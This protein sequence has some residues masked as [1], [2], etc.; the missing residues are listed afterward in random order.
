M[1]DHVEQQYQL[2]F[3]YLVL[4]WTDGFSTYPVDFALMSSKSDKNCFNQPKHLDG[5]KA[6][7]KRKI[8]SRKSKPEVVFNMIK[9]ALNKGFEAD[10][11]LFDSWFTTAPLIASL[12]GLGLHVIGMLKHMN[13][14]CY[15]YKKAK[16]P[17]KIL[18]EVLQRKGAF[19]R[20]GNGVIGS[21]VVN[22]CGS[23]NKPAN[24]PV[25]LVF[26]RD[27]RNTSKILTLLCTDLSLSDEEIIQTYV[28]RWKIEEMFYT[29]I[30]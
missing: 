12:R 14:N 20:K 29:L 11:V 30:P 15:E 21:V 25:K 22:M 24:I 23:K 3:T 8:E 10:Y 2:G 17:L 7:D 5:R 16:Y 13:N 19:A 26:V 18:I 1:Y 6:A 27:H 4:A 9:S 28:K